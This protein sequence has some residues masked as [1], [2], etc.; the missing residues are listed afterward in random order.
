MSLLRAIIDFNHWLVQIVFICYLEGMHQ[1]SKINKSTLDCRLRE[2]WV[3]ALMG[4]TVLCSS[5]SMTLTV[6]LSKHKKKEQ[7]SFLLARW[8]STL[9]MHL[10]QLFTSS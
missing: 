3:W 10:K 4:V 9:F 1:V 8:A 7:N 2:L 5:T 6:P